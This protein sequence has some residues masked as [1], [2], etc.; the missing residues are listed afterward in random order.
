MKT[1]Q[2]HFAAHTAMIRFT[3]M[4]TLNK[5]NTSQKINV[6]NNMDMKSHGLMHY[7]LIL[8]A[9]SPLNG[10]TASA[11]SFQ[12]GGGSTR[13]SHSFNISLRQLG[14]VLAVALTESSKLSSPKHSPIFSHSLANGSSSLKAFDKC[15]FPHDEVTPVSV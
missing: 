10:S 13:F 11:S 4:L 7:F 3:C 12:V 15:S 2:M 9:M 1:T 8:A 5:K 6:E 14:G